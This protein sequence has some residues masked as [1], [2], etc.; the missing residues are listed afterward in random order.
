MDLGGGISVQ[1]LPVWQVA[2]HAQVRG[3]GHGCVLGPSDCGSDFP[4]Q[5]KDLLLPSLPAPRWPAS[6]RAALRGCGVSVVSLRWDTRLCVWSC[7][8][9]LRVGVPAGLLRLCSRLCAL[10]P[11]VLFLGPAGV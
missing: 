6:L 8:S 7:L 2:G 9:V 3:Q 5:E 1:G 4:S 10:A 11:S